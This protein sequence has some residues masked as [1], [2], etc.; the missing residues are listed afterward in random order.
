[1]IKKINALVSEKK[2]IIARQAIVIGGT[3]LGALIAEGVLNM[4]RPKAEVVFVET[5]EVNVEEND[6]PEQ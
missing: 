4:T 6:N 1:M 3:V 2:D 5:T